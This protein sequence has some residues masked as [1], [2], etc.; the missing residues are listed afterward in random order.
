MKY[1]DKRCYLSVFLSVSWFTYVSQKPDVQTSRN[2]LFMLLG[3]WLGHPLT[4]VE[5][6][7]YLQ[8]CG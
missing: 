8:F 7:M 6:I 2:F 1:S 3:P 4:T 5:Y